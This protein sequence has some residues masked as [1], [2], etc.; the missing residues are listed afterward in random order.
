[1]LTEFKNLGLEEW[2]RFE[3]QYLVKI[4]HDLAY[5]TVTGARLTMFGDDLVEIFYGDIIELEGEE[6]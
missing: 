2:F 4:D 1:M 3:G 5:D 6:D